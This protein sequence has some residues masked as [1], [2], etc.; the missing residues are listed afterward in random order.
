M[1]ATCTYARPPPARPGVSSTC[2]TPACPS[3]SRTRSMNGPSRPAAAPRAPATSPTEARTPSVSA[4]SPAA[5]ATGTWLAQVR[6]AAWANTPGPYWTRPVTPSGACPMVVVPQAGQVRTWTR[7][8]VT[9]GRGGAGGTSNTCRL[10]SASTGT[11][12]RS[13]PHPAQVAGAHT[14]VW[15]GSA[16]WARVTPGLPGLRPDLARSD[17]SVALR[18]FLV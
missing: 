6:L 12:A 17:R 18:G 10:C 15:S 8:S 13:H 16:T 5:R 4:S 2:E 14:I 3:S 7:H 1:Q 9:I 11:P